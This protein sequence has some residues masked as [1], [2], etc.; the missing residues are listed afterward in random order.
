MTSYLIHKAIKLN[1]LRQDKPLIFYI[2]L[3]H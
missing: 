3:N 1:Y 2:Y